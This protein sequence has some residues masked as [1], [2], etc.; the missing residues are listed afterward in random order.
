MN[1]IFLIYSD[2]KAAPPE[3]TDAAAFAAMME[4]WVAYTS[5]LQE[6]GVYRGGDALHRT[7]EATT[8][9]VVNGE[10]VITDG[11][12]AETREQLGGYYL[13]EC[14]HLDDALHWASLCPA[15]HYGRIE[16]RP[17]MDVG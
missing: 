1:Y 13:V 7:D 2:E 5:A 9:T 12:F 17:L 14:A 4:P 16:V 10:K 3:P 6:A 8:V 11:P 15:A